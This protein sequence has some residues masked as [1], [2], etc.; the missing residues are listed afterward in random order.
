MAR[1]FADLLF[2]LGRVCPIDEM[3]AGPGGSGSAD[4]ERE[5]AQDISAERRVMDL[6]MELNSPHP[7]F[8][9]FDDRS[10][11]IWS[12]CGQAESGWKSVGGSPCDIQTASS[13]GRPWK[14]CESAT[15][16]STLAWP[17]SRLACGTDFAAERVD[18]ELQPVADAEHG[19][20]EFEDVLIGVGRAFVVDGER[21]PGENDAYGRVA[22]N[23]GERG[24]EREDDREDLVFADAARDELRILRAK[25]EDD[26]GL[27]FHG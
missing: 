17:Y 3:L 6:R 23:L 4:V 7:A 10:D 24:V 12:L 21:P 13:L 26:D 5:V 19:H 18:H 2:D 8:G 11:S 14:S 16:S 27:G 22:A 15:C 25:V 1:P 9:I 20:A